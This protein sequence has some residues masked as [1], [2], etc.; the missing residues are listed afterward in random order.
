MPFYL[1]F[2]GVPPTNYLL[3][4][5][6]DNHA[7]ILNKPPFSPA[8]PSPANENQSQHNFPLSRSDSGVTLSCPLLGSKDPDGLHDRSAWSSNPPYSSAAD[9]DPYITVVAD[10]AKDL[11]SESSNDDD[12]V[13][14]EIKNPSQMNKWVLA[15][16]W[17]KW[18][19][20]SRFKGI[21]NKTVQAM[22][23]DRAEYVYRVM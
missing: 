18:V 1:G 7:I 13:T 10:W 6:E 12:A 5:S 4:E 16:R 22:S 14:G 9:Y 23:K 3:V 17:V 11:G 15:I 20:A 21:G 8:I 2:T 19:L